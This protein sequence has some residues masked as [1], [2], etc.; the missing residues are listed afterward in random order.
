MLRLAFISAL[1]FEI[2]QL[3]SAQVRVVLA[4]SSAIIGRSGYDPADL[5]Q[6]L[7]VAENRKPANLDDLRSSIPRW[8]EALRE[9]IDT[10]SG[11][12]PFFHQN[13]EA[14][15]GGDRDQ[16]GPDDARLSA[17][18]TELA[19]LLRLREIVN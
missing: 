1:V 14:M 10:A 18:E 16:R 17:K 5:I 12:K 19:F 2:S 15:H 9:Q 4:C 3:Q 13:V 8:A 6:L 7:S 11:P